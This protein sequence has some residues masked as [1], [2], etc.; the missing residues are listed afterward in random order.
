VLCR[1]IK[2]TY[3]EEYENDAVAVAR[4]K[5]EDDSD[6]NDAVTTAQKEYNGAVDAA[7]KECNDAV[8]AAE[9]EY[10]NECDD[11]NSSKFFGDK[12]LTL[13]GFFGFSKNKMTNLLLLR[14][15]E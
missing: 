13:F 3:L 9:K 6:Y 4:E 5:Y 1:T 10:N 15:M 14:K 2:A 12:I 11:I 7:W 8:A